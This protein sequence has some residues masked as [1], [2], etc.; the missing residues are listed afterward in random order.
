MFSPKNDGLQVYNFISPMK[1][2]KKLDPTG[3]VQTMHRQLRPH[4]PPALTIAGPPALHAAAAAR[5]GRLW[6][7]TSLC[8]GC[9]Q[10]FLCQTWLAGKSPN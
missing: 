6:G 9:H 1:N 7:R 5:T 8:T 10:D 3:H 4:P 2:K